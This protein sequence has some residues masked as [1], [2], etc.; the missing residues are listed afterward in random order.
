ME[1]PVSPLVK[2]GRLAN[3]DDVFSI[4]EDHDEVIV[5]FDKLAGG[6]RKMRCTL[7]DDVIPKTDTIQT[8]GGVVKDPKIAGLFAVWDLDKKGW[9]S[10]HFKQIIKIEVPF[11]PA[12]IT[13]KGP[14]YD[15]FED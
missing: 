1:E 4:F 13:Y 9:R 8:M 12:A 7:S 14:K 3:K 15:E 10:F 11:T 2:D 5:T 6:L